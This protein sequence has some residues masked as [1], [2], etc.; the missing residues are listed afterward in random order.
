MA[1]PGTGRGGRQVT[2]DAQNAWVAFASFKAQR[3]RKGAMPPPERRGL[4][5][6]RNRQTSS[7]AEAQSWPRSLGAIILRGQVVHQAGPAKSPSSNHSRHALRPEMASRRI[8][9]NYR[10]MAQINQRK[11]G[12]CMV[13]LRTG[14]LDTEGPTR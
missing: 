3:R 1:S 9:T 7:G 11:A 4:A 14:W 5:P 10:K 13:T 2:Q 8:V 12:V 6:D